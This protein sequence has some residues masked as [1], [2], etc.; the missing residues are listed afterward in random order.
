MYNYVALRE[1]T[2]PS[3][4][5]HLSVKSISA[6]IIL[7]WWLVVAQPS[8]KMKWPL[9]QNI[10]DNVSLL[11]YSSLFHFLLFHNALLIFSFY[12]SYFTCKSFEIFVAKGLLDISICTKLSIFY[13]ARPPIAMIN[14][15]A[16]D[17]ITFDTKPFQ[18][19]AFRS[20]ADI[21]VCWKW[22]VYTASANEVGRL[23]DACQHSWNIK[24]DYFTKFC[25]K[26]YH[27]VEIHDLQIE[28]SQP[29]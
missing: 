1:I 19:N 8:G 25:I 27:F 12:Y 28:F 11:L 23:H 26:E 9:L 29:Q 15:W 24:Q 2:R 13:P 7:P 3:I 6:F 22:R 4:N 10:G 14:H 20:S 5:C 18:N 21:A 16:F 17:R